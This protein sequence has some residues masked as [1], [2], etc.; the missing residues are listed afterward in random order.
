MWLVFAALSSLHFAMRG[1]LFQVYSRKPADRNVI[2]I[3]MFFAGTIVSLIC[4]LINPSP[5]NTYSLLGIVMGVLSF[6]GNSAMYKAYAVGKAS[7]IALLIS[8][9]PVVVTF[10]AYL[11]WQEVLTDFQL[12][13]LI[14]LMGG[15]VLV[16]VS[17]DFT[18]HDHS[19]TGWAIVTIFAF[20]FVDLLSKQTMRYE[21]PVFHVALFMFSSGMWCF[22]IN[23]GLVFLRKKTNAHWIGTHPSGRWSIVRCLCAGFTVGMAAAGGLIFSLPAMKLGHTGLVSAVI[24]AQIILIVLYAAIF[25]RERVKLLEY[26]G[27]AIV[28]AGIVTLVY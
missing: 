23:Y 20:A 25:R 21:A 24:N 28:L 1:I 18:L 2:L 17:G 16:R 8:I 19:G 26:V 7:Y 5:W 3:G 10:L 11:F 27:I 6:V 4:S 9:T 15:I 13:A 14:I 12:F 22:L